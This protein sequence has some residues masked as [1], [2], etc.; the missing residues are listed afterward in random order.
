MAFSAAAWTT[1]TDDG[2]HALATLA[3]A[4]AFVD[5]KPV[6]RL[7]ELAVRRDPLLR[8]LSGS[9]PRVAIR[10]SASAMRCNRSPE[11]HVHDHAHF[12][13]HGYVDVSI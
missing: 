8:P 6:Y 2:H 11:V 4:R 12:N 5:V 10:R 1:R 9:W 13:R 7:A 3:S